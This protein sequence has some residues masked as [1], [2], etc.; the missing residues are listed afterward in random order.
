MRISDWSSDVC[1]SDLG[2]TP[3][4][5]SALPGQRAAGRLR[6]ARG[7]DPNDHAQRPQPVRGLIRPRAPTSASCP[8]M[9]LFAPPEPIDTEAFAERSAERR[10]GKECV[11]PLRSRGLPSHQKK[12]RT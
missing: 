4:V 2:A 1:S 11:S 5:L 9:S 6:L 12:K 10:V 7:A 8:T 3:G